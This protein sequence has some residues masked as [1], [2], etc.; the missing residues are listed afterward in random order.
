MALA[1]MFGAAEHQ[2]G[3][4]VDL[5]W[6]LGRENKI[7]DQQ[8]DRR[9]SRRPVFAAAE[10]LAEPEAAAEVVYDIERAG[11]FGV[12]THAPGAKDPARA[13]K[14]TV[15][16]VVFGHQSNIADRTRRHDAVLGFFHKAQRSDPA[17]H[18]EHG[19]LFAGMLHHNGY[20]LAV[21]KDDAVVTDVLPE[22]AVGVAVEEHGI[23][24]VDLPDIL[25]ELENRGHAPFE[26][27]LVIN[28]RLVEDRETTQ[29]L[30]VRRR[31]FA[32]GVCRDRLV[33]EGSFSSRRNYDATR[34]FRRPLPLPRRSRTYG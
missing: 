13:V 8:K 24:G 25:A 32:Y 20:R 7:V 29:R 10:K 17:H 27:A 28:D 9:S 30:P 2:H 11:V 4:I 1:G 26:I 15:A 18:V 19:R 6:M 22:Y 5:A 14:N 21:I 3:Q 23:L 33:P 34:I 16:R 31:G 12:V